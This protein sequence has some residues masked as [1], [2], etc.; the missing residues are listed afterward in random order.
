MG[1]SQVL[2]H[3]AASILQP[4][5]FNR[6]QVT[7]YFQNLSFRACH[8][9]GLCC[10]VMLNMGSIYLYPLLFSLLGHKIQQKQRRRVCGDQSWGEASSPLWLRCNVEGTRGMVRGLWCS[11]SHPGRLESRVHGLEAECGSNTQGLSL[12]S[13]P[14]DFTAS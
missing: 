12:M 1:A 5:R 11:F 7:D 6:L 14:K 8:S 3:W 10:V 2:Y 9:V 4:T 13:C